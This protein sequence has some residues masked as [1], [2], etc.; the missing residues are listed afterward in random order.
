MNECSKR[1]FVLSMLATGVLAAC[2]GG[3]GGAALSPVKMSAA[4]GSGTATQTVYA[5]ISPAY[6][7]AAAL[8]SSLYRC[9]D[10]GTSGAPVATPVSGHRARAPR[11]WRTHRALQPLPPPRP[12]TT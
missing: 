4:K 2:G 11:T 12:E 6:V 3:G 10:G 9:A 7:S 8:T 1:T 5:A